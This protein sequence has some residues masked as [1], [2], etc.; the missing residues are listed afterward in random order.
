LEESTAVYREVGPKDDLGMALAWLA[1]AARG[2]GDTPEARQHLCHAL[3]IARE[4]E[5]VLPL[6]WVLPATALLLADEGENERAV[7]LYALASRYLL[8]AKSRWFADV[9]GN[10]LAKIAASLPAERVAV[11]QERGRAR[12]LEATVAELLAELC[13]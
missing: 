4:S 7:E 11:L 12:D 2:P 9:A 1:I 10:T 13:E 8:V 5:T 3:E 6:M